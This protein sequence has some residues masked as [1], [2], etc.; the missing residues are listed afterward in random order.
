MQGI[1]SKKIIDVLGADKTEFVG[2]FGSRARGEAKDG[3]DIDILVR[4]KEPQGLIKIA[5]MQR[6]LSEALGM[7]VDL[8]TERAL[9]PYMREQ[10][11]QELVLL[12]GKR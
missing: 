8:V 5:G 12:H 9:S 10:V 4:F 11:I 7:S 2:V 6:Q 3:S 1:D